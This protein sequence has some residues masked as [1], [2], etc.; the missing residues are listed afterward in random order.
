MVWDSIALALQARITDSVI[1]AATHAMPIEYQAS[2]PNLAGTLKKRRAVLPALADEYYDLLAKRVAIHGT[3][4]PDHATIARGGDGFVDVRLE[5]AGTR[6]FSR[7][8]DARETSELLVYLHGGND[9]A[10]VVGQADHSIL[11]RIIGGNG[12]NT[13][14]DSSTVAGHGHPSR[15]YDVGTV[16][17]VSYGPDTSFD[18]LPWEV[19]NDSLG[20]HRP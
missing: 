2:A 19:L 18:R 12:T 5:S 20:P 9:T 17:G 7:R 4:G 3:D 8:F 11:I 10:V 1:V 15:L 14:V 16:T 6:Y 13:L